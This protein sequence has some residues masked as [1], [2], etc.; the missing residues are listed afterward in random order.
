MR[1]SLN[2][3]QETFDSAGANF[4]PVPAGNYKATV[5]EV[6]SGEVKSG[7]NK[8]KPRLNVQFRIADGELSPEGKKVGNRRVFSGIN[9]FYGKSAKTGEPVAPFDLVGI[10]KALG[11]TSEDLADLDTDDWLG[12]ELEIKVAHE[13]KKTKESNYRDSYTPPQFREVVKGY[14]SL[15]AAET[16]SSASATVKANSGA[17]AAVGGNTKFT[18]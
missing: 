13:E 18:L 12:K 5:F 8:G 14:R 17:K 9:A 16:A 2:V 6:T 15:E 7:D 11:G 3:D 1:L 4:E 10:V